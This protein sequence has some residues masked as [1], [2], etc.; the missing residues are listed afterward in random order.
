MSKSNAQLNIEIYGSRNSLQDFNRATER[1][2]PCVCISLP[3]KIQRWLVI[4]HVKSFK[5]IP[6]WGIN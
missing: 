6:L 2:W 4:I 3:R 1:R 5:A